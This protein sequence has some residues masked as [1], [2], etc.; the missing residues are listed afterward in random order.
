MKLKELRERKS[1]SQRDLEER[2]GVSHV[3]INRIERGVRKPW[4]KTVRKLSE[5]LG[6][7]P[8]ELIKAS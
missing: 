1:L 3:T 7:E 8:E 6:V 2:S 4:P 5:A